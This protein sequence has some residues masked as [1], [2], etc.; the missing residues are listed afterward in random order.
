MMIRRSGCSMTK[1]AQ[2]ISGPAPSEILVILVATRAEKRRGTEVC[3]SFEPGPST[4]TLILS[5]SARSRGDDCFV[6]ITGREHKAD[7]PVPSP[8]CDLSFRGLSFA[9]SHIPARPSG[10]RSQGKNRGERKSGKA[11]R[12][13]QLEGGTEEGTKRRR[14]DGKRTECLHFPRKLLVSHFVF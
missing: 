5:E 11:R 3:L 7:A 6:P 8:S 14:A 12:G 10:D 4:Q 1:K 13:E 2:D 9:S